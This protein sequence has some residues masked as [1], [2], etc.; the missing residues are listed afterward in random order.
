MSDHLSKQFD[1]ELEHIRTRLLQMGGLV[2]NQVQA[3]IDAF[4]SGNLEAMQQVIDRDCEVDANEVGIDEDCTLLIARRQPTARD[5]RLVMAVSRIVTDLERVGDKA[6]KI[7]NMS[8]KLH[9]GGNQRIPRL[10]DIR[11]CGRLAT[12]M[13]QSALDSLARMDVAAARQVIGADKAIDAAF[14]A[15]LRQL[16]TYMMEDP[17]TISEALDII[18][19]AKAIERVG[20]H[21]AN[22]AENVIYIVSGVDVRH[23]GAARKVASE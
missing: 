8:R 9:Q 16:I 4:S 11:H 12:D 15:I 14:N 22:I 18:W 6:A 1:L 13:L 3:A 7:A 17:R 2:E 5:L 10:S 23:S 19:I 21:A 20:D